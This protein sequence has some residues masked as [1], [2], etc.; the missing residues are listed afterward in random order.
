ME[1]YQALKDTKLRPIPSYKMPSKQDL[2][3][4]KSNETARCRTINA[5]QYNHDSPD[6]N[7]KDCLEGL[8]V[9]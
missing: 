1:Y 2:C 8:S 3:L 5:L 9:I 6:K 4:A 7:V